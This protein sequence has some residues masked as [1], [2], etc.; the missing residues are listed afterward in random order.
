M[1]GA[2][3]DCQNGRTARRG[4]VVAPWATLI[5]TP[6]DN[7]VWV[8]VSAASGRVPW[9][10]QGRV[11][12]L[13]D[14]LGHRYTRRFDFCGFRPP[15]AVPVSSRSAMRFTLI[16]RIVSL[17]PGVRIVAVKNLTMAEEYL[18]D[19]FPGFPVMPGV[20]MLQAMTEA[21]AWLVRQSENFAHSMVV[22]RR[23]GN[24]KYGQFVEPG[25]TLT[26]S[27]EIQGETEDEVKIK[28]RGTGAGR[29]TVAGRLT[30]GR[31]N[32]ADVL[33][34]RAATDEQIKADLRELFALL[35]HPDP[36]HAAAAR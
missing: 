8:M 19:H 14:A 17:E 5:A 35:Y 30:L 12:P 26:V 11:F 13:V 2:G 18:S 20:L 3:S 32:L 25:Q 6:S 22:L 4:H 31:Y 21:G 29:L 36:A 1:Q 15:C 16:D 27:A 24:V 7:R 23:A 9:G 10:L 33:P 28:A 34:D